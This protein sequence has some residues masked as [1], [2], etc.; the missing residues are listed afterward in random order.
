MLTTNIKLPA[1][2][3]II[4]TLPFESVSV[5]RLLMN[6]TSSDIILYYD[7]IPLIISNLYTALYELK[8]E[9]YYGFPDA[10]HFKL[11]NKTN[12]DTYVKVLIDTVP[13]TQIN[14]NYFTEVT[15]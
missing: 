9:S 11:S 15:I 2:G 8:F 13:S 14:E 6:V 7:F 4:V 5:R 12:K 3:S 10:S 1:G